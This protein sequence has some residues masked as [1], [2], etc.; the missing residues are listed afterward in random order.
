MVNIFTSFD[1]KKGSAPTLSLP[2]GLLLKSTSVSQHNLTKTA[3]QNYMVNIAKF[4]NAKEDAV[5]DLVDVLEF[6]LKLMDAKK[7]SPL[8]ANKTSSMISLE[9]MNRTWPSINWTRLFEWKLHPYVSPKELIYLQNKNFITKFEKLMNETSKK[10][11]AN[12]AIWKIIEYSAP[13]VNSVTLYKF[14]Q[15]YY[16]LTNQSLSGFQNCQQ[17]I[18]NMLSDVIKAFYGRTYPVDQKVKN[19]ENIIFSNIKNKFIDTLNSSKANSEHI[20]KIKTVKVVFGNPDEMMDDNN[21]EKYFKGLEITPDNFLVNYLNIFRFKK[22]K[23][24]PLENIIEIPS[25]FLEGFFISSDCYNYTN[26]AVFGVLIGLKFEYLIDMMSI[27]NY[28]QRA[29]TTEQCLTEQYT[30]FGENVNEG[31]LKDRIGHQRG[32]ELAYSAYREFIEDKQEPDLA[33]LYS[34]DQAF[35][36]SFRNLYCSPKWWDNLYGIPVDSRKKLVI[37][38][39]SNIPEFSKAFSCPLGSKMNPTKKCPLF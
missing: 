6:E 32:L 7:N 31:I 3:Y 19:H 25:G 27:N 39:L 33:G 34:S 35:W 9:E 13:I 11:Q 12:Y 14:G 23:D 37:T 24:Y 10:V 36:L 30:I 26:Y 5:V 18:T 28:G 4:F 2:I 15:T 8:P 29:Y 38:S 21:L 22:N 20:K 17:M 16:A 1:V